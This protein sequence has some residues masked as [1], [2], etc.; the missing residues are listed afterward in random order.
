[1][2]YVFNSLILARSERTRLYL[3]VHMRHAWLLSFAT[4]ICS[5]RVYRWITSSA[6][7]ILHG[8]QLYKYAGHPRMYRERQ[9]SASTFIIYLQKMFTTRITSK[10]SNI[11]FCMATLVVHPR[12]IIQKPLNNILF[13]CILTQIYVYI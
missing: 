4:Y 10:S 12:H 7:Q 6:Q 8:L 13:R 5:P 11:H 2:T 3:I 9:R 1:M